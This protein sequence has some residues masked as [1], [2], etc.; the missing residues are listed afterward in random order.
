MNQGAGRRVLMKK[1]ACKKSHATVPLKSL[2]DE[3]GQR[4][5]WPIWNCLNRTTNFYWFLNISGT[6]FDV[7]KTIFARLMQKQANGE[8]QLANFCYI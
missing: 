3:I 4:H 5:F 8:C 1:T 6:P 7:V 2:V